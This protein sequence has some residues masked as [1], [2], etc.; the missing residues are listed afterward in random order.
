MSS[1]CGDGV[2]TI[3]WMGGITSPSKCVPRTEI[4]PAS[5]ASSSLT[6]PA[7][8]HRSRLSIRSNVAPSKL[9]VSRKRLPSRVTGPP[10]AQLPSPASRFNVAFCADSV[11]ATFELRNQSSL[12]IV[13]P[14]KLRSSRNSEKPNLAA[15][16]TSRPENVAGPAN[17]VR[18]AVRSD[19]QRL[20]KNLRR[21]LLRVV[22]RRRLHRIMRETRS[23]AKVIPEASK[24]PVEE[25]LKHRLVFAG[26]SEPPAISWRWRVPHDRNLS[27]CPFVLIGGRVGL[28]C[29][30]WQAQIR[31]GAFVFPPLS[32]TLGNPMTGLVIQEATERSV[33]L[34]GALAERVVPGSIG[35]D[36]KLPV[37]GHPRPGRWHGCGN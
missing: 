8:V 29:D 18:S 21:Q 9:T 16:P 27:Q 37:F 19:R 24:P 20:P 10:Y 5:F 31:V 30:L 26:A 2:R 33:A 4:P 36:T 3:S 32:P 14:S 25:P 13:A 35:L 1:C 12:V 28:A 22:H 11:P 23:A 7:N 15:R 6:L 34:P 17:C